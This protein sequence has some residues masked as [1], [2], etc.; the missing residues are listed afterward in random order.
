MSINGLP[1]GHSIGFFN[2]LADT[3]EMTLPGIKSGDNLLA[4][5][6]WP[7]AGTS[8]RGD[9][10]ADFTVGDG[11]IEA[12]TIDLSARQCVAIWTSAPAS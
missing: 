2:G 12:A 11:T 4:V 7:D 6:S 5:F 8:V 1:F 3:V 9:A 10:K